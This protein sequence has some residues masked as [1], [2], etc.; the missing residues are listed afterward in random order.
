MAPNRIDVHHHFNPQFFVDVLNAHG[1]DPSGWKL[2]FW[3]EESDRVVMQKHGIA[4]SII[5][6]TAPGAAD[7]GAVEGARLARQ[8]NEYAAKMRDEDPSAYGFLVNLPSILDKEA[9]LNELRYSLDVLKADG[10]CLFTRYGSGHQYLGH[11]DF[12]YLWEELNRRSAV[13]FIHPTHLVDTALVN[14]RLLQPVIDYPFETTKAAMDLIISKTIRNFK[15]LKIILSH[16]GGTLPY[17]IERAVNIIPHTESVIEDAREF[18]YDTALSGGKN[19]LMVL[20]KFAKP[21]HILYG[22]DF[23][24]APPESVD[25]HNHAVD[26]YPFETD[27]FL[28]DIN[29]ANARALFPRLAEYQK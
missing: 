11:P 17:L 22:S 16:A 26:V 25:Y 20:E 14:P 15:S 18:Y 28:Q 3:S 21:G 5:S 24:Y 23:P 19:A 6:I 27:G 2:P 29:F 1:G 8:M 10:V 4:T 13:M 12:Q 9:T 7:L